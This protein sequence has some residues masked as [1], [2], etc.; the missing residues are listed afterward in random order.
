[1]TRGFAS[2]PE[3]ET[4]RR[5]AISEFARTRFRDALGRYAP[6]VVEA[7]VTGWTTR[8]RESL[9]DD[10]DDRM[11]GWDYHGPRVVR[12]RSASNDP[13]YV[14]RVLDEKFPGRRYWGVSRVTQ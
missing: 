4:R 3:A 1:M 9:I 6:K 13:E 14:R 12:V 5:A 7:E 11:L 10:K 8:S 2:T